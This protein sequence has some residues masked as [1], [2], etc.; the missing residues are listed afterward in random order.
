MWG[1]PPSAVRR[2]KRDDTHGRSASQRKK[3]CSE[4]RKRGCQQPLYD[5]MRLHRWWHRSRWRRWSCGCRAVAF[6]DQILQF[7]ARLEKRNFLRGYFHALPGLG[8]AADPGLALA[9]AEAA[10]AA[11]LDLV[12]GSQRAHHAVKNGL[13]DHFTIF[14]R[15]FC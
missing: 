5:G 9:G 7:L 3:R 10:K 1:Q 15:K 11:N 4:K 8:V 6:V 13:Y 12:A 14:A 2:A